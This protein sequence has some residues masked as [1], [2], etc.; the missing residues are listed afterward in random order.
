MHGS[1][2]I[3]CPSI[4][5]CVKHCVKRDFVFR[6]TLAEEKNKK[7]SVY[8]EDTD[9]PLFVQDELG[10]QFFC[11]NITSRKHFH[12]ENKMFCYKIYIQ[13]S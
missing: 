5:K 7:D 9:E 6:D 10:K 1:R 12:N 3:Y 2:K 13:P 11:S 8:I 4:M